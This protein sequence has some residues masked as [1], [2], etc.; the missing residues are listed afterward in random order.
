MIIHIVFLD[1]NEEFLK[2]TAGTIGRPVLD[3][4]QTDTSFREANREAGCPFPDNERLVIARQSH[5]LQTP[6]E[7]KSPYHLKFHFC[8]VQSRGDARADLTVPEEILSSHFVAVAVCDNRLGDSALQ[9]CG[10]EVFVKSIPELHAECQGVLYS[11]YERP[12]ELKEGITYIGKNEPN[13]HEKLVQEIVTGLTAYLRQP[14]IK[15]FSLALREQLIGYQSEELGRVLRNIYEF[16]KEDWFNKPPQNYPPVVL[17]AGESGTGKTELA[18]L[19]HRISQR[20]TK[21][22]FK[23]IVPSDYSGNLDRLKAFLFGCD[24]R[25][26]TGVAATEGALNEVG[27][28]TLLLD[29]FHNQS[30]DGFLLFHNLLESGTYKIAG[31]DAQIQ[32]VKCALI[33]TVET[34]PWERALAKRRF[35][36]ALKARAERRKVTLPPLDKRRQDIYKMT[37]R[38]C[39]QIRKSDSLQT[40]L[41]PEAVSWLAGKTWGPTNTRALI[42]AIREARIKGRLRIEVEIPALEV[43][44]QAL[45]IIPPPPPQPPPPPPPPNEDPEPYRE[46]DRAGEF[47]LKAATAMREANSREPLQSL[48]DWR[49]LNRPGGSLARFV[50]AWRAIARTYGLTEDQLKTLFRLH[51]LFRTGGNFAEAARFIGMKRSTLSQ[52][53]DESLDIDTAFP[54]QGPPSAPPV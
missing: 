30:A 53:V 14:R 40:T 9:Q 12:K 2:A 23:Q 8:L 34:E 54:D 16:A 21:G 29:D 49:E 19:L 5:G 33:I 1:D 6:F 44:Y 31:R 48:G 36:P 26:F 47:E 28:G 35:S 42:W 45:G 18:Q 17:L 20:R 3:A 22:G 4:L 50:D 38:I 41:R 52:Y 51:A 43:A 7:E 27:A 39:E 32:F 24:D 11:A 46:F 37:E 15:D 13:N 25:V 10:G